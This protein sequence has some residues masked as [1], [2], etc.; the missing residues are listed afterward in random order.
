[1][2]GLQKLKS[3]LCD[4]VQSWMFGDV[5]LLLANALCDT[6]KSQI[7]SFILQQIWRNRMFYGLNLG[8][9]I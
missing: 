5:I 1:M 8:L 2:R 3:A 4:T 7:L 9:H 6:S